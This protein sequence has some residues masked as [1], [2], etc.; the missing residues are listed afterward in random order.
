MVS[1]RFFKKKGA[2]TLAEIASIAE[3][4]L[5]EGI[6]TS[7]KMQDV[8]PLEKAGQEDVS[9]AFIPAVREALKTTKAGAVIVPRKFLSYVPK[10]TLALI[11]EDPHRSYG[12]LASAFYP[13]TVKSNISDK[14]CTQA[15]SFVLPTQQP[16][17][18]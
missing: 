2:L 13:Y 3:V 9:W 7:I 1:E 4:I 17:E 15:S 12:L 18:P 16:F 8:A 5:P 10:D 6:D 11:S 14:A